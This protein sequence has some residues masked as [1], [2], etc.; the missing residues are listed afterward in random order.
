MQTFVASSSYPSLY[1]AKVSPRILIFL[2]C[3]FFSEVNRGTLFES[4]KLFYHAV[5]I[6]LENAFKENTE[7][8]YVDWSKNL[9]NEYVEKNLM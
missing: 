6:S 3:D 8:N 5:S 1:L 2:F 4:S 7:N 9:I